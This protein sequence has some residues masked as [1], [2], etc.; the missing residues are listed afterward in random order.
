VVAV[1]DM[2]EKCMEIHKNIGCQGT[3]GMAKEANKFIDI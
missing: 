2:F 1:E 3:A